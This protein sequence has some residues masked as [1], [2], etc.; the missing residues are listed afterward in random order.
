MN[1]VNDDDD[2]D[3]DDEDDDDDDDDEI[4]NQNV[5]TDAENIKNYPIRTDNK[6]KTNHDANLKDFEESSGSDEDNDVEGVSYEQS[7][8]L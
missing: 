8:Y 6:Q 4:E 7:V 1:G 5:G 3:D 2:E